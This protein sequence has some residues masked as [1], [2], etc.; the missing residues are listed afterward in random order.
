MGF[1]SQPIRWWINFLSSVISMVAPTWCHGPTWGNPFGRM[2]TEL[3]S[4]FTHF[5]PVIRLRKGKPPA[6]SRVSHRWSKCWTMCRRPGFNSFLIYAAGSRAKPPFF[7]WCSSDC[8]G[9]ATCE[10]ATGMSSSCRYGLFG[11]WWGK[12]VVHPIRED[13]K[14]VTCPSGLTDYVPVMGVTHELCT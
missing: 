10:K 7:S 8:D 9:K 12:S 2:L 13:L 11:I 5:N 6:F 14:A 1:S 4:E 3:T